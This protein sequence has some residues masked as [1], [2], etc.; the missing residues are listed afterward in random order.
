MLWESLYGGGYL[1]IATSIIIVPA[2]T[3]ELLGWPRKVV[4]VIILTSVLFN[5][6]V[7]VFQEHTIVSKRRAH[8]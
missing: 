5:R 1:V 3:K 8:F 4:T 6:V 2:V 7:I